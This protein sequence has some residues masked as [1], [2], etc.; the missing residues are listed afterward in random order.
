MSPESQSSGL[1]VKM[2]GPRSPWAM[3]FEKTI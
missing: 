1:E 3:F 2:E